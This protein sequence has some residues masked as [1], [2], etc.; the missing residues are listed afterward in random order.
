MSPNR[1]AQYRA[2]TPSVAVPYVTLRLK[3]MLD[4]SSK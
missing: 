3:L 4:A 1:L 2:K